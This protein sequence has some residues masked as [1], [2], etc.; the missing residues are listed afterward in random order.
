[1]LHGNC[2]PMPHLE[3]R[4]FEKL[5]FPFLKFKSWTK[6]IYDKITY[7]YC[8][9]NEFNPTFEVQKMGNKA[10]QNASFGNASFTNGNE[11]NSCLWAMFES[12]LQVKRDLNLFSF[13]IFSG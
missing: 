10:F 6:H 13:M 8:V 3:M 12:S 5:C 9:M 7:T 11:G 4:H 1:M 2:K